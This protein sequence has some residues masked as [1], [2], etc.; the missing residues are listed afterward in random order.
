MSSRITTGEIVTSET[1]SKNFLMFIIILFINVAC[2]NKNKDVQPLN[3]LGKYYKEDVQE[4]APTNL[5]KAILARDLEAVKY[6]ANNSFDI[7]TKNKKFEETPLQLA[8]ELQEP[9]ISEFLALFP[10]LDIYHR[11]SNGEGYLFSA[12]KNGV[13]RVIQILYERHKKLNNFLRDLEYKSLDFHNLDRQR[14]LHKVANP[15]SAEALRT[16]STW[17]SFRIYDKDSE[18]R[19][20]LHQAAIDKRAKVLQWAASR[21]CSS[22]NEYFRHSFLPEW[23]NNFLSSKLKISVEFIRWLS[24]EKRWDWYNFIAANPFNYPDNE[25]M[26]SLHRA[27]LSNSLSTVEAV[28]SCDY[29]DLTSSDKNGLTPLHLAASSRS[30]QVLKTILS[31][32]IIHTW[33]TQKSEWL[34]QKDEHGNT[35]LHYAALNF[36]NTENYS[37][38]INAGANSKILNN[39]NQ[40][41]EDLLLSTQKSSWHKSKEKL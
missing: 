29:V 11:N 36:R 7:N 20:P 17:S 6:H 37:L 30:P 38:L 34:N 27:V 14:S 39:E 28:L 5:H 35:A 25:M 23:L 21:Y 26:S 4:I 24:P 3:A 1:M 41:P 16:S 32:K 19:T 40:S 31:G 15:E 2:E 12:S 22:Y 9:Q 8:L 33:W 18:G 13:F 10:S